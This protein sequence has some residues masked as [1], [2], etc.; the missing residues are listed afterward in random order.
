[1]GLWAADL[2]Q[3]KVF[4]F[5]IIKVNIFSVTKKYRIYK[6][7]KPGTSPLHPSAPTKNK[8]HPKALLQN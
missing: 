3:M 1:M 8:K 4:R 5:L 2:F 7:L 6:V